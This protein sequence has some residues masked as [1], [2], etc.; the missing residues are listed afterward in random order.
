MNRLF[1]AGDSF[2]S[3][4]VTQPAG[5]SWSEILAKNLNLK[6][7][8]ISRPAA[9]NFSI[10][11]QIEWIYDNIDPGDKT[12]IFLTDHYRKT[13]VDLNVDRDPDKKV[14][15][16]HSQHH[17]QP[18]SD[19]LSLSKEPRLISSMFI[20]QDQ[21]TQAYYRD[22]YDIEIQEIED[23]LVL[24]GALCKLSRKTYEFLVCKG[25]YGLKDGRTITSKIRTLQS[26]V[27]VEENI[28]HDTFCIKPDQFLNCSS[29]YLI[30]LS[31]FSN[32]VN[33]MDDITHAKLASLINK[34]FN[35]PV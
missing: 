16:L 2:A 7:C 20:N 26:T 28:D 4:D 24:T 19:V 31:E 14:L 22:W 30:S 13:L 29:H 6:L 12:V 3:L 18:K 34:K 21:N 15:E 9:S 32:Y 33:H 1:V 17:R 10:S 23:R 27:S 25:G 8:N 11:L 35:K 5:Y